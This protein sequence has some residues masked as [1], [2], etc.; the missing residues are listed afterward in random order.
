MNQMPSFGATVAMAYM[1]RFLSFL[2]SDYIWS[3]E[4]LFLLPCF[5]PTSDFQGR[6]ALALMRYALQ[7]FGVGQ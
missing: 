2:P 3:F 4:R 5:L 7:A 1:A 6:L